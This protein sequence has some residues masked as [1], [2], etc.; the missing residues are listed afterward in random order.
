MSKLPIFAHGDMYFNFQLFEMLKIRNMSL[1][2]CA[3]DKENDKQLSQDNEI[4]VMNDMQIREKTQWI[5]L[6]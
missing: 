2:I 1:I 3:I 5:A 4:T 6:L